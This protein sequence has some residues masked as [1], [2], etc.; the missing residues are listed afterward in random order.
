MPTQ[1]KEE[2]LVEKD[3]LALEARRLREALTAKLGA[4]FALGAEQLALRAGLQER[5]AAVLVRQHCLFWFSCSKALSAP[6]HAWLG[7]YDGPS[8]L[9]FLK[10]KFCLPAFSDMHALM[11]C[12]SLP[13]AAS[14]LPHAALNLPHAD[15][16]CLMLSSTW[17]AIASCTCR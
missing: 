14:G 16:A 15:S 8:H 1:A 2:R 5:K 11:V 4:V 3:T 12:M 17:A 9:L 10:Q 6:G 7:H 13:H